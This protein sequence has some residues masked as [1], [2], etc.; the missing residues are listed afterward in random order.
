MFDRLAAKKTGCIA[1]NRIRMHRTWI[2]LDHKPEGGTEEVYTGILVSD[3]AE[4]RPIHLKGNDGF[5]TLPIC[6]AKAK[7]DGRLRVHS[8][9][10]G[11]ILQKIN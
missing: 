7:Q 10:S 2:S 4:G 5:K 11:Y 8:E 9:A 1:G 3:I 6:Y